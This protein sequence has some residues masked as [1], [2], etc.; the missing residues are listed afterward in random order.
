M[1]TNVGSVASTLSSPSC[2]ESF[3]VLV[4]TGAGRCPQRVLSNDKE[5]K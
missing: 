4:K 1:V 2:V 5:V 3:T